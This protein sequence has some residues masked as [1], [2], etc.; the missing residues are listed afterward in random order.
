MKMIL[1]LSTLLML[2]SC[3]RKGDDGPER[4]AGWTDENL[5]KEKA[6]CVELGYQSRPDVPIEKGQAFC[7]CFIDYV[8]YKY[9][10]ADASAF[11]DAIFSEFKENG[12]QAKCREISGIKLDDPEEEG[13]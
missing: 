7:A 5:S 8:S 2:M 1:T 4:K 11:G 9:S 10:Y 13:D 3:G 6:D 12:E